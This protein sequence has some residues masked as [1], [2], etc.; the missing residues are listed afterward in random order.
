MDVSASIAK[1]Q[2]LRTVYLWVSEGQSCY[3]DRSIVKRRVR[4]TDLICGAC[5]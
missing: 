1:G 4:D 2:G 3:A 5:P